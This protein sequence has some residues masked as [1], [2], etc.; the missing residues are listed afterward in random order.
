MAT[1]LKFGL[2]ATRR[3]P[4]KSPSRGPPAASSCRRPRHHRPTLQNLLS[5]S[6]SRTCGGDWTAPT[7]EESN[8]RGPLRDLLRA[9]S[10][11][12]DGDKA[13]AIEI[14]REFGRPGPSTG[15]VRRGRRLG[16]VGFR[17]RMMVRRSWRPMLVT[18]P[19]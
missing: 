15:P 17:Y 14:E 16:P 6:P 3:S 8:K 9:S 2:L 7:A 19:E 5:R 18:I 10:P 4:A 11:P 13:A 12:L 1:L